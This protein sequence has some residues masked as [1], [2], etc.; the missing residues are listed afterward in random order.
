M[1]WKQNVLKVPGTLRLTKLMK[2]KGVIKMRVLEGKSVFSGIAIGKISQD[3]MTDR[4][5]MSFH[6]HPVKDE[7]VMPAFHTF[8][9]WK[10][11]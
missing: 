4:S 8:F 10:V 1:N 6:V 7:P 11:F 3:P 5:Y 2:K 9:R